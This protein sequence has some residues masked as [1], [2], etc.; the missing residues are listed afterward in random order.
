MMMIMVTKNRDDDDENLS[1]SESHVSLTRYRRPPHLA[2]V[3]PGTMMIIVK[4]VMMM[5]M[6]WLKDHI[7]FFTGQSS[8][9]LPFHDP[10]TK[11][12]PKKSINIE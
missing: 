12:S 7:L 2:F 4:M 10:R 3:L 1:A 5:M 8:P 6:M 9:T 11:V